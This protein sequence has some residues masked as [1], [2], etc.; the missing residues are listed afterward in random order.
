MKGELF[1]LL[2]IFLNRC[3]RLVFVVKKV[4]KHIKILK[5]IHAHHTHARMVTRKS[6]VG[7]T[8]HPK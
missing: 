3:D 2:H 8:S 5:Y 7:E 6:A 1:V 4:C